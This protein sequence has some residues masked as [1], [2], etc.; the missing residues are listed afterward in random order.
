MDETAYPHPGR[1]NGLD[2]LL[3]VAPPFLEIRY[4]R[5]GPQIKDLVIPMLRNVPISW[6]ASTQTSSES[7][8]VLG[9][10]PLRLEEHGLHALLVL[11]GVL[12]GG[13]DR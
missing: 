2:E 5:L 7:A 6:C 1:A 9:A 4:R 12:F 10:A 11:L 13:T 8:V 3:D